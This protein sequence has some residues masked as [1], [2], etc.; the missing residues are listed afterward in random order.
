MF[1]LET[2]VYFSLSLVLFC[3]LSFQLLPA[4]A[5]SLFQ[6]NGSIANLFSDYK[7]RQVGD[8]VT[9]I[10]SEFASST[11]KASTSS[12]KKNDL[13]AGDAQIGENQ[14]NP[15]N[16]FFRKIFPMS[17]KTS[18]K[19]S[20]EG[21]TSRS[22]SLQAQLTAV[23]TEILPNGNL[24]IEG[25]QK[26]TVNGEDQEIYVKGTV[27]PADVSSDNTVLS[28]AVAN[29]EIAYKGKG[30]IGETQKPGLLTRIFHWL[31]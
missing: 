28:I 26:I 9:I 7:A 22:G 13:S 1:N 29:A 4:E 12:G 6:P 18:S 23:V 31:F 19:F 30:T 15:I 8:T 24:V 11:Q 16:K 10:V 20:G 27:R 5:T 17:G 2:K 25:S 3:L 14:D 21:S